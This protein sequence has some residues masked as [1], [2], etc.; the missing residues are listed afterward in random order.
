MS[1]TNRIQVNRSD[2]DSFR[3]MIANAISKSVE[4]NPNG[5]VSDMADAVIAAL[6][7]DYVFV[8]KSHSIVMAPTK[9][10]ACNPHPDAPHGFDRNASHDEGRYVCNCEYWTP[11]ADTTATS[12]HGRTMSDYCACGHPHMWHTGL[13]CLSR[14]CHCVYYVTDWTTDE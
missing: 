6:D 8:P 11:P 14:K 3:D 13:G 1:E 4:E 7:A 12:P 9:R 5:D 2:D 10:I